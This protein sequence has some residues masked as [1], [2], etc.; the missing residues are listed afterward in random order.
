MHLKILQKQQ[1][2]SF[3][4]HIIHRRKRTNKAIRLI[5]KYCIFVGKSEKFG[6]SFI[7]VYI[8]RN[9]YSHSVSFG[10]NC[11]NVAFVLALVG[12]LFQ[13]ALFKL[14]S[15][16]VCCLVGCCLGCSYISATLC[17]NMALPNFQ[18][19]DDHDAQMQQRRADD[20]QIG[21]DEANILYHYSQHS[22]AEGDYPLEKMTY[23]YAFDP[24]SH[25]PTF[26]QHMV[27]KH[28]RFKWKIS[29]PTNIADLRLLSKEDAPDSCVFGAHFD[30]W[31]RKT[32]SDDSELDNQFYNAVFTKLP[33]CNGVFMFAKDGY[34]EYV[35]KKGVTVHFFV[36]EQCGG[37]PTVGRKKQYHTY[38]KPKANKNLIF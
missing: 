10:T 24:A 26:E 17:K 36:T 35:L 7:F 25:S 1:K 34:S 6:K 12:A 5:R 38:V 22:H 2:Q 20:N 31:M 19:V 29:C 11:L 3:I 18:N 30:H 14:A 21:P 4:L 15:F 33:D 8:F 28:G 13:L 27:E 23:F 32:A 16:L 9:I 37:P